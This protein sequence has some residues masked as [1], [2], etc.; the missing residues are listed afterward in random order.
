[1]K[2]GKQV[3][4]WHR[5]PYILAEIGVAHEGN[6]QR[7]ERLIHLAADAGAHGVKFQAYKAS[8]LAAKQSPTYFKQNGNAA[9]TQREF[10]ARYDAL[11]PEDYRR[12]AQVATACGVDFLCTPFHPDSVRWLGPLVP[13]WKIASADITNLPLLASTVRWEKPL[14]LS[15]GAAHM[16]EILAAR[17]YLRSLLPQVETCFLHCVLSYPTKPEMAQLGA[18]A[19][20]RKTFGDPV[21]YSDH[22]LFDADALVQAWLLG[23]AIIEK[24]FTD[25]KTRPGNDHYHS[26]DPLD[27][28]T[29]V[30]KI[31]QAQH[32]IGA[33]DKRIQECEE[34]ARQ[35][36]R[37]SWHA[38]RALAPGET[39]GVGDV[40]IKRPGDGIPPAHAVIGRTVR[41][42]LTEDSAVTWRHLG[43]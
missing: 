41:V 9:K 30:T 1:M 40:A 14:L 13:A 11:N 36:A 33:W 18:I 37:Q 6:L 15:T 24:H 4:D 22:L 19:A 10:F 31:A 2:I 3:L 32:R 27:L 25:D 12:L 35:H 21:G 17:V 28:Q 34:S 7:A 23:A 26:M 5:G 43:G 39:I 42:A 8:Q 16:E 20:L 38:T 29:L